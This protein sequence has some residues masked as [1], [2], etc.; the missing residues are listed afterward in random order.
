MVCCYSGIIFHFL[1]DEFV[2]SIVDSF[3]NL[4]PVGSFQKGLQSD[5]YYQIRVQTSE[6]AG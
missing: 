6:S 3:A 5:I 4:E 1:P 2:M